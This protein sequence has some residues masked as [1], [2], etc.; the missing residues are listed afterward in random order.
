MTD[1]SI[2]PHLIEKLQ[3]IAEIEH[4]PIEAVLES[5]IEQ[6]PLIVPDA[7]EADSDVPPLG[8]LARL[9]YEMERADFHS[10]DPDIVDNSRE[11]LQNEFA[12]YLLRRMDDGA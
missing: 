12:D 6:Y 11:I 1:I 2:A 7:E 4:R 10:G 9:V 5:L 8:T 3:R